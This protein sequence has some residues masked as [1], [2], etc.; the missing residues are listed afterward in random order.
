MLSKTEHTCV[1]LAAC[2]G[3]NEELREDGMLGGY[4][5]PGQKTTRLWPMGKPKRDIIHQGQEEH[6]SERRANTQT[7]SAG[8]PLEARANGKGAVTELGSL[9]SR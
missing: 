9:N 5:M 2:R 8:F 6:A 3:K 4:I 1:A 7:F